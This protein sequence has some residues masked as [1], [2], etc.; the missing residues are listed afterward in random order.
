[1]IRAA[2]LAIGFLVTSAGLTFADVEVGQPAPNF[3]LPNTIGKTV[4]L[5]EYKGKFVVL[6]WYNPDCPFVGKHYRSGNMQKLQKEYSA[7][8]VIWLAIDSSAP[9]EEGN[10]PAEKLNEI[11]QKEGAGWH[12]LLLDPDGKI[13]RLYGAKTTPDMYIVDPE[14]KV[15]YKGAIDSK[16]STDVA[17]IKTAT[18]YV[19]TA[20]DEVIG[21]KKVTKASTQS[22]GCSVKY[23]S[24]S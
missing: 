20:L 10:Y 3:S 2:L 16:R 14:G 15:V 8:G 9:G 1:M 19:S 23:A 24:G 12:A 22:Y 4:N 7:K 18:N 11:G 6:E 17:D 21:G 5:D 13:G